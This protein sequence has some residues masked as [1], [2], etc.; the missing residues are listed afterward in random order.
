MAQRYHHHETIFYITLSWM[1]HGPN[2]HSKF[3]V[4]KTYKLYMPR[5]IGFYIFRAQSNVFPP[6]DQCI[7]HLVISFEHPRFSQQFSY[8]LPIFHMSRILFSLFLCTL[9]NIAYYLWTFKK[10]KKI[11]TSQLIPIKRKI[12]T[13]NQYYDDLLGTPCPS[14]LYSTS[15]LIMATTLLGKI[16]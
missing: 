8:H 7:Y 3:S 12:I 6:R 5:T 4:I 16:H 9:R 14:S 1:I 13:A 2:R 10:E 15:Y 11:M